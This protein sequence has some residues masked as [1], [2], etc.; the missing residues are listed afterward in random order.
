MG[1]GW[2]VP[3]DFLAKRLAAGLLSIWG[4]VSLVFAMLLLTGDPAMMLAGEDASAELIG[5]IS[6]AHGYDQPLWRQY[7]TFLKTLATGDFP[8]SLWTKE[9]SFDLVL[10][11]APRTLLLAF[12]GLS[13]GTALGLAAGYLAAFSRSRWLRDGLFGILLALNSA[14]SFVL[15]LGLVMVF[16][17]WL[18]WLPTS[19]AASLRHAVLPVLT[20]GLLIAPDVARVFRASIVEL[21]REDHV[22]TALAKGISERRVRLRHIAMNALPP[23]VAMLGVRLGAVLGG[24]VVVESVFAW[25][26]VGQLL[27]ESV[28]ARDYPVVLAA[29]TLMAFGYV[30]ANFLTDLV[31]RGLTPQ[32][33]R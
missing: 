9:P 15:A 33:G 17:L 30:L 8:S 20:L 23:V 1:R 29:A 22:A 4:A 32:A 19:G 11:R 14:P 26:G 7:L 31:V 28:M 3:P 25:P 18:G 21:G 12:L 27:L 24:S 5:R 2:R 10:T 6:E 13:L 16:S